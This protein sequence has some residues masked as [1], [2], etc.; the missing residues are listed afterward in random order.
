MTRYS[1]LPFICLPF[2]V[3]LPLIARARDHAVNGATEALHSRI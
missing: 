3:C 1:C 2:I